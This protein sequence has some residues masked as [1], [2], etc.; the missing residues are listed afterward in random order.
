MPW[1]VVFVAI[2]LLIPVVVAMAVVFVR[3]RQTPVVGAIVRAFSL[4][5]V[6]GATGGL[7]VSAI[8]IGLALALRAAR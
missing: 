1:V 6:L 8:V 2:G 4:G 7:I 3:M 5:L